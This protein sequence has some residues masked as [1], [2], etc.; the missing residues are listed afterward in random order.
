MADD[1]NAGRLMETIGIIGGIAGI[2][3]VGAGLVWHFTEAPAAPAAAGRRQSTTTTSQPAS[4]LTPAAQGD[5]GPAC[6][7]ES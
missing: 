4:R 2:V 6:S 3:G 7:S 5:R 1:G